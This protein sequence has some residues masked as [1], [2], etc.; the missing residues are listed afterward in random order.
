MEHRIRHKLVP[1]EEAGDAVNADYCDDC[2][3]AE[4]MHRYK[5]LLDELRTTAHRLADEV[6]KLQR[7]AILAG[8]RG[9]VLTQSEASAMRKAAR[10]EWQRNAE[11]INRES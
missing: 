11:Q 5:N 8:L 4:A 3:A 6:L 10:E 1:S 7:A 2:N 9:G